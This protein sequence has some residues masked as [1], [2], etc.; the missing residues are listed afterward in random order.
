MHFEDV[1]AAFLQGKELVRKERIYVKVPRGYPKEVIDYLVSELGED[2][3]DDL[4]E[5][6]K[7]GFGLPES[8]RLWYLEYKDTIQDL[9]LYEMSLLPQFFRAFHPPPSRR[10]R[11]LASIHVDDTRYAGDDTAQEI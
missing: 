5:L 6:T 3:R 9:G 4:V 10:V 8:P 11:A 2:V 1:S 7:G